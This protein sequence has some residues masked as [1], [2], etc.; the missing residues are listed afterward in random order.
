MMGEQ[1]VHGTP[2]VNAAPGMDIGQNVEG[3]HG[4]SIFGEPLEPPIVGL[5][6]DNVNDQA[7]QNFDSSRPKEDIA[8]VQPSQMPQEE[9]PKDATKNDRE[10]KK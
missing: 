7:A 6:I 9:V 8:D 2:I 3:M 5:P 4:Q 1:T 10:E